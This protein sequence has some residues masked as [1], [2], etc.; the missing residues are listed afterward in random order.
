MRSPTGRR[1]AIVLGAVAVPVIGIAIWLG[2]PHLVFFYRFEPLGTNAQGYP[3]CRHRQTGIVMVRIPGGT[4]HMG[5]QSTDPGGPNYDPAAMDNEWPVHEVTVSPFL[6]GKFEV[7]YDQWKAV[8]GE[9]VPNQSRYADDGPAI[10]SWDEIQQFE[11]KTRLS[12]PTE[13]QWEYACRAGTSAPYSGT[14]NLDD[15]GWYRGN[16]GG[17]AHTVGEKVPNGFGLHDT[18]GNVWELCEDVYDERFY[19]KPE[20]RGTDP[21][22]TSGSVHHV[23]R[24]GYW[25]DG[26]GC[27]RSAD[28]G[29]FLPA[30][31]GAGIG[32]RPSHPW[33]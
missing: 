4:F 10:P 22:A 11:A 19:E 23:I 1:V 7:T 6:I 31:S 27:C 17:A 13:A 30:S 3:E 26:A 8:M 25:G 21:M 14:G 28:R 32:F 20:A 9:K 18:H 29:G 12:L 33:P 16:G 5:A 2:W 24:G 15:M